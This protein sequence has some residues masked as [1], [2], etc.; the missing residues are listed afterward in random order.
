V[1]QQLFAAILYEFYFGVIYSLFKSFKNSK[2]DLTKMF[3]IVKNDRNCDSEKHRTE[4]ARNVPKNIRKMIYIL[5]DIEWLVIK[6]ITLNVTRD[7][8]DSRYTRYT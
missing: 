7:I 4:C 2:C 3:L 6:K 5:R 8:S 1:L